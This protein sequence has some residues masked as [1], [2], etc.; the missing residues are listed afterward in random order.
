M[1]QQMRFALDG[2]LLGIWKDLEDSITN[3]VT[4]LPCNSLMV[5]KYL[6]C[7][8]KHSR[9]FIPLYQSVVDRLYGCRLA[10][11]KPLL[12]NRYQDYSR[13]SIFTRKFTFSCNFALNFPQNALPNPLLNRFKGLNYTISFKEKVYN[14]RIA[15]KVGNF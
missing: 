3:K 12:H 2:F 9:K 6:F 4:T 10:F 15:L 8:L 13:L 7:K 1:V 11:H 5:R 14:N